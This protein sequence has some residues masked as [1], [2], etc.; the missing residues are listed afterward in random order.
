MKIISEFLFQHVYLSTE[1][2]KRIINDLEIKKR[3]GEIP[4]SKHQIILNLISTK[5]CVDLETHLVR[6]VLY[7]NY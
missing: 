2:I 3:S 4:M 1:T 5:F 7:L 6:N